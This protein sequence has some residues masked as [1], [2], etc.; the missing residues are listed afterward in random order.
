MVAMDLQYGQTNIFL[1][2][3]IERPEFYLGFPAFSA[4]LLGK[5]LVLVSGRGRNRGEARP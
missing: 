3:Y 1:F 2:C 5:T 4:E